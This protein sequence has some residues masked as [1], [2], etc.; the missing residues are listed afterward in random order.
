[1]FDL[2]ISNWYNKNDQ[3][4]TKKKKKLAKCLLEFCPAESRLGPQEAVDMSV[5]YS[6]C[7]TYKISLSSSGR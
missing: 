7:S 1:M 5:L 6:C 3:K 4:L 2:T